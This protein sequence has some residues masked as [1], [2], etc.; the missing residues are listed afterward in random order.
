LFDLIA[1]PP[2]W[3][4]QDSLDGLVRV[5]IHNGWTDSSQEDLGDLQGKYLRNGLWKEMIVFVRMKGY[6]AERDGK[7]LSVDDTPRE[8]SSGFG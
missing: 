3:A 2:C 8:A 7:K 6:T 1:P 4:V 5:A